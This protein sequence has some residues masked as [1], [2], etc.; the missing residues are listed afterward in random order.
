MTPGTRGA[1]DVVQRVG[2]D[3]RAVL[4]FLRRDFPVEHFAV[5]PCE[6]LAA[7]HPAR[8]RVW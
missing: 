7:A 6:F 8:A 3:R 2:N 5:E 4:H 1:F